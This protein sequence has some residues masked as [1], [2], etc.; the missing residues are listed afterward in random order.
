VTADLDTRSRQAYAPSADLLPDRDA[1]TRVADGFARSR[2]RFEEVVGWLGEEADALTHAE[3]EQRLGA[4][5]RE[6]F[7]RLL[8][9][10]LD[11]RAVREQRIER[12]VDADGARRASAEAGHERA[13]ATV[14]GEVRVRRVAYRARGRCNLYPADAALNLPAEKH[15]HGLRRLAAIESARGSFGDAAD[16]VCRA[17][18]RRLG[19]R[20]LERLAQRSAVDFDAFY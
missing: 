17:T 1:A 3:L 2:E 4:D 18:G 12:V 16:A 10:H 15:S 7:R 19:K 11:L 14:F 9:D 13:L 20:Q 6:L 5:A 8:Q